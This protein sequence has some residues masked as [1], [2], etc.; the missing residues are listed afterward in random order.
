MVKPCYN[1]Y[2]FRIFQYGPKKMERE[3]EKMRTLKTS[4]W[5]SFLVCKYNA[6]NTGR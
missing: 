2:Q 6:L 1:P 3:G 5:V 4:Y